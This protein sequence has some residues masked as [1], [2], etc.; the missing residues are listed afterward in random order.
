MR[1]IKMKK[2]IISILI[3][4]GL[5][6]GS[7]S[8]LTVEQAGELLEQ[9][10]ID[11]VPQEVLQQSTI[12][13]MLQA[14]G[15]P[16]TDYYTAQEYA[17][18]LSG[19]EDTELVGIGIRAYYLE[20]GV[21][22]T[23][24]LADSPAGEAG[25]QVGDIIIAIDGHDT[26][27][28]AEND[29][30]SWIHGEQGTSVTLG[31][32]R[33]GRTFDVTVT[34][35][36]VVF[37]TAVLEKIE[38]RIG[39][40]SCESFGSKTFQQFYDIVSTYDEEV[41]EW[42]VDLR[43]N[44]GGD[45][46]SAL[47][48]VGCFAG[49]GNGV[50]MRSGDGTY[51]GYFFDPSLIAQYGYYDGEMSAFDENGYVTM[52]PAHVLVNENTASA[53]ELFAAVIRDSGAG[54]VIG[55]RTYGKGVAQS[56]FSNAVEGMSHYFSQGDALKMTTERVYAAAGGTFDQVGIIPHFM[57][58]ADQADEVAQL[59]FAP[60]VEGEEVLY[61]CNLTN[62][63]R[64]ADNVMIPLSLLQVTENEEA[65]K[66]LMEGLPATAYYKIDEPEGQ[67][68]L[69]TE[70]A[71]AL[72]GVSAGE[73]TFTDLRNLASGDAI[74]TL[75]SYGIVSG[76]GDGTFCPEEVLDRASLCAL[77]VKA[78]RYPIPMQANIIFDDVPKDAWFAPY[79]SALAELGLVEG[80]ETGAFHPY[81]VVTHEEFLAVMGRIAQWLNMDYY[82]L[83]RRDGIYGERIPKSEELEQ[84][85]PDYAQWARELVWLCDG[86][87][88]W[89]RVS[90]IE[91]ESATTREEAAI[92]VYMLLCNSGVIPS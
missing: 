36:R 11:E 65:V 9:Y 43:D 81:D 44:S 12:D 27:G 80:D 46:F 40:I 2:R 68:V 39:W 71:Q 91:A 15:D 90:G 45:V 30:D 48:S 49:R 60:V 79:V 73:R 53:A 29:V 92:S 56:L 52:D 42:V 89:A 16:Y 63:S 70:E 41:D 6:T 1:G 88:T 58:D 47:F 28:A 66:Q 69:R 55:A 51:Y 74:S 82:E 8:A 22:L 13:A 77:L 20:H 17:A 57:V 25:L 37:P 87:F 24:V 14:L 67:R 19:L 34:R 3:A 83:A 26:R 23:Q 75:C 21:E 5:L 35:R 84:M 78:M 38:N 33:A 10:Y 32:L 7:V 59:L 54:L 18:F 61:L 85:Y 31:I 64:I 50:Y 62:T 76:G 86:D 72:C 4:V